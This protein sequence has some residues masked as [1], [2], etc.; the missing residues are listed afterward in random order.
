MSERKHQLRE[1]LIGR[2]NIAIGKY[3]CIFCLQD[4]EIAYDVLDDLLAGK[5]IWN[6]EPAADAP[7]YKHS[8]LYRSPAIHPLAT[9]WP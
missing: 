7:G 1:I 8:T 9:A 5:T 2:P 4:I 6:C 3:T